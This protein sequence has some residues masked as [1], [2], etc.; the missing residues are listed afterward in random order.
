MTAIEYR[1]E[2]RGPF[3]VADGTEHP[4]FRVVLYVDGEWVNEWDNAWDQPRAQAVADRMN[5]KLMENNQC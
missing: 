4:D 5:K 1:V 2:D 3:Q